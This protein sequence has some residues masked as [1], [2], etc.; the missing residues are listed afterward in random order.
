MSLNPA[1]FK[2][3]ISAIGAATL[4]LAGCVVGLVNADSRVTQ[5]IQTRYES[6]LLATEMRQSSDDL[7]RLART[8]V[9][10]G[11]PKWEQQY[12]EVLDIRNGKKPR[13]QNYERIYWDFRAADQT[14]ARTLPT[15]LPITSAA[16]SGATCV[17]LAPPPSKTN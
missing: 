9:A 15:P 5:A 11:D 12:F 6:S 14:P 1:L 16:S 4:A 13:P 10:T 17:C 2:T 8:F 3:P 7:T